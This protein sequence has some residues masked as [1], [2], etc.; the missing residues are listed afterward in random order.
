M[1]GGNSEGNTL[2]QTFSTSNGQLYSVEFDAAISGQRNGNPLQLNVQVLGSG[3]LLDQTVTP[4]D[5]FTF[6]PNAVVF[7]HYS[8]T[9]TANSATTTLQFSDVGTW[10]HRRRY[11]LDSVVLVPCLR[12][13]GASPTPAPAPTTPS[14]SPIPRQAHSR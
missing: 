2:S 8:F 13:Q 14:P 11:V 6:D 9:F 12:N 1:P 3:T 4:S 7:D 5:A 10:Q